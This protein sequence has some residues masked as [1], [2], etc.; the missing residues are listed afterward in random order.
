MDLLKRFA[1]VWLQYRAFQ[2]ALAEFRRLSD[3][4]LGDRGLSRGDIARAAFE[5]AERRTAAFALSRP[6]ARAARGGEATAPGT[7]IEH[8]P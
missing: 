2:A 1:L 8:A 4:E 5:E 7:P 6:E 3:R